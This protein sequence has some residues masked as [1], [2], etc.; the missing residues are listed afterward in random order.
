MLCDVG[1][2]RGRQLVQLRQEWWKSVSLYIFGGVLKIWSLI[3]TVNN[4]CLVYFYLLLS[5][6]YII[7]INMYT[8]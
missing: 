3:I 1:D 2:W 8:L 5:F 7:D 4:I 6:T